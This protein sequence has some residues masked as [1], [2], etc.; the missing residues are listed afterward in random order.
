MFLFFCKISNTQ[1]T[2]IQKFK[3]CDIAESV[4]PFKYNSNKQKLLAAGWDPVLAGNKVMQRLIRVTAPNARGAHDAE[5][6]CVG[7]RAYVVEHDNDL[8]PGHNAAEHQYCVLSVVNL[9]TLAVDSIIPIA[10]SEQAFENVTLPKGMCFVPRIIQ[11]DEQTLR[12]YF[13]SQG[14]GYEEQIWYRDFNLYSQTFEE[15]I[16]K[17]KLKTSTGVFDMQPSYFHADAVKQGFGKPVKGAGLY[18]F[19]S[20]KRFGDKTYVVLN[21]FIAKQN[22]LALLHDDFTT[23]EVIGHYNEPQ[24]QQL[25]ESAVNRL[26]DGTWMAI[27][28]NDGGNYHFTTSKDG[29]TWSEGKEMPFVTNG[30]NSKPTFDKFG[31]VYYLGWQENTTV[32]NCK[33]SVFN[34]DISKDGMTWERK[35]RFETPYSFQ[36]PTFHE[37]EGSIWLTVTQS[38]HKGS[39]DRIMFG[40]LETLATPL[41]VVRQTDIRVPAEAEKPRNPNV[42]IIVTDDQGYGDL[43]CLGNPVLHTPH[44]D[45]LYKNSIRFTNFHVSP[46][47]TPSRGQLLSGLDAVHNRATAV[48][49]GREKLKRDLPTM[50]DVFKAGSYTTGLFGKWHLG[51]AWPYRPQDRGF[52]EVM[53]FYGWGFSGVAELLN[54]YTDGTFVHNGKRQ[55]FEGY[56]TDFWFDHAMEWMKERQATGEPF[57]CYLATNTA[58]RPM[59]IGKDYLSRF[60][61]TPIK[62]FQTSGFLAMIENIDDNIGRLEQ[63]LRDQDLYRNTIVVFLSDNGTASG[64]HVFNAGMRGK[65]ASLYEGGHRVPCFVRW[66]GAGLQGG[67]NLDGLTEVQDLLPTLAHLVGLESY[68]P[69]NLDGINLEPTLRGEVQIPDRKLVVQ[70]QSGKELEFGDAAVL[71]G[72]W[73]LVRDR[74]LYHVGRDPG[75]TDNLIAQHPDIVKEM[76]DHYIAWWKKFSPDLKTYEP[77]VLAPSKENPVILYNDDMA[78]GGGAPTMDVLD[79]PLQANGVW[80]LLVQEA[81]HYHV[82]VARWPFEAKLKLS[83][84][85]E[86]YYLTGGYRAWPK[87]WHLLL[88]AIPEKVAASLRNLPPIGKALPI[89]ATRLQIGDYDVIRKVDTD[90]Q[91]SEFELDLSAGRYEMRCWFENAEG[92]LITQAPYIEFSSF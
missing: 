24:S 60:A 58:H 53:T 18:I 8:E 74:E 75:Q 17:A 91:F 39:S 29:K 92:K 54:D 80:H 67:R 83:S 25:S 5:F 88:N 62:D 40:K 3:N 30:L 35:Y 78:G 26:P 86:G 20:F 71:W 6:V 10:R 21:N 61:K 66:P 15:S 55:P 51:N 22:A 72:P 59:W 44:L 16:H 69:K 46:V 37:Y 82:R 41:H 31:G 52:D 68:L 2:E 90:D 81:G 19:D 84:P 43:A 48:S 36:Y 64:D 89:Q 14:E 32:E 45:K 77:F 23:F 38:D 1:T 7:E 73:R 56:A 79:P 11:K 27:C 12:C 34:I 47:C 57:F 49:Q 9:N 33:R 76:R 13:A 70:Y 50:A 85:L 28:R 65:K 87:D 63:F 4:L 42:I